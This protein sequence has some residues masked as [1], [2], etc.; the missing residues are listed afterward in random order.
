MK[1]I[2]LK[3]IRQAE[4]KS[5]KKIGLKRFNWLQSGAE[6]NFT[7][8]Q[9][10]ICLD[11]IKI[12]PKLLRKVGK[13]DISKTIF[14]KKISSSLILSPMGHQT[15]FHKYGE[16]EMA[17][18]I[19]KANTLGFFGTQSRFKLSDIRRKN[20]KTLLC[21]TIFPFGNFEWI[22]KQVKSAEKNKC[23]A[24]VL[25]LDANI[26]SH[27][28][29]D[30]E[31]GYDARTIGIRTN[32]ISPNPKLALNYDWS[33]ITRIKKI[34]KLPIIIKGVLSSYDAKIAINY[35][36]DGL[37]ISNHGGRMFNSGISSIDALKEIYKIKF[38]KKPI[39]IADGGVRRGSDIIKYLCLGADLVGIGRPAIHGLSISGYKGVKNIFD[40]LNSEL[41]TAMINGG[42]KN[43]NDFKLNRLKY[44]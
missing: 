16:V 7:T 4:I 12:I 40:I 15:Q 6:D 14:G 18:G 2:I 26:R 27:R 33:L 8:N 37:W 22:K 10:I 44:E 21:W 31:T 3:T 32:P 5:K 20:K 42:F 13:I 43:Y 35:K 38:R 28:Y 23:I 17:K 29:L 34:T 25:C 30:R 19:Y 24:L 41:T 39:I 9:N 1:T 11:K 36:A